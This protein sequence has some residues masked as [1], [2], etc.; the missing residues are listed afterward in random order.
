M[1]KIWCLTLKKR[2]SRLTTRFFVKHFWNSPVVLYDPYSIHVVHVWYPHLHLPWKS[3]IHVVGKYTN[4]MDPS[5]DMMIWFWSRLIDLG[6]D[7]KIKEKH[8]KHESWIR[9]GDFGVFFWEF[10]KIQKSQCTKFHF[11]W[12]FHCFL[13]PKG[14]PKWLGIAFTSFSLG[15]F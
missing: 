9:F 11:S 7:R 6:K 10:D 4:P 13:G 1:Y 2:K 8:K 3:T 5:W 15:I 14:G 12:V